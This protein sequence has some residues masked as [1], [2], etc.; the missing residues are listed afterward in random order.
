M[1]ANAR[2]DSPAYPPSAPGI[3]VHTDGASAL[4]RLAGLRFVGEEAAAAFG[5]T[6]DRLLDEGA[7]QRVVVDF[8]GVAYTGSSFL[9]K[10]LGLQ[11]RLRE[12]G[13]RLTLAEVGPDLRRVW[14][15]TGLT[16][17]FAF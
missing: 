15:W 17:L 7:V 16:S 1:V 13:G 2:S 3:E 9:A 4:I 5:R 6:A 12:T 8:G 14:E 11:R 10:L